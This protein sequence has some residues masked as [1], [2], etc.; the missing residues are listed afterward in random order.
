MKLSMLSR[1]LLPLWGG[2]AILGGI[3]FA[4]AAQPNSSTPAFTLSIFHINDH[5]SHLQPDTTQQL[6][7]GGQTVQ[8]DTGGF[9]RVTAFFKSATA[10]AVHPLKLHAGDAVTGDLYY[11]L[12]NG[13]ADAELMNTVCFDAYEVGNHEFDNGDAGLKD[14]LE[15]LYSPRCQTPAL[16]A[17]IVPEI[18]HSA[19]TPY[20]GMNYLKPYTIKHYGKEQV[21]IIGIETASKTKNSSSP[22]ASTQFLD[23]RATAQKYIDLLT[24]RGINKIVVLSHYG[25][26][27]DLKLAKQLKGVDVIVG[28]DSH[29]LLGHFKSY[30]LN[31]EGPYPTK[32][33]TADG[34]N[35][36]I[37]Q[38][39]QYAQ[40]V[41]ELN[42]NFDA[43]GHV[44][45]CDGTAHLLLGD[46]FTVKQGDKQVPVSSSARAAIEKAIQADPQLTQVKPDPEAQKI[47]DG[48]SKQVNKMKAVQIGETTDNL[49]LVRYPG[50]KRSAICDASITNAHGADISNLVAQAFLHQSV[51]AELSIQ[52]GG[53]VRI[54]IPKGK[55]TIGEAYL[56]LPFAN[57]LT[58]LSMTGKE[59]RQ[60]LNEAVAFAMKPD[61]STGAYPY[62]AGIR[63]DV[64]LSKPVGQQVFNIQTKI[65]GSKDWIPLNDNRTYIVVTNSYTAKGK[66]GYTTFADVSKSG[67]AT[68]TY[69]DYAQSFVDYVKAQGTIQRPAIADYS[70]QHFYNAKGELLK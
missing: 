47:L 64:D 15:Y 65:K 49:C 50:E 63:Y 66:D 45:Q 37:V 42:V 34:Q 21:G 33:K 20:A 17:N 2:L 14:F 16:G 6:T 9:P 11:T 32:E 22:D 56:L 18:G 23:E 59:I 28:G 68:D 12:F 67:R 40:V 13:K 60:V 8:V 44:T 61:G 5:H 54:D 30:G 51:K 3:S 48:Y 27:N 10:K 55:I 57:T 4:H 29:T 25:Y 36:C 39:W 43:H 38:A 69:L 26:D 35:V 46:N 41:G 1:R 24:K 70:T 52:N 58:D 31:A 62:G 19:L 7:L 53:G